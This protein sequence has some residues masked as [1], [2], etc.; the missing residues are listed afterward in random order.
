MPYGVFCLVVR[1]TIDFDSESYLI[2]SNF[3]LTVLL[4]LLIHLFLF[5]PFVLFISKRNIFLHFKGMTSALLVA[6]S[7]SSSVAT[8]PVTTKCLIEDLNYKQENPII[9]SEDPSN[10]LF[11]ASVIHGPIF[12]ASFYAGFRFKVLN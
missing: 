3:F 6:F 10:S 5:Y 8:I 7:S 2:L 9:F 1:T 12:G 11:D 4:G